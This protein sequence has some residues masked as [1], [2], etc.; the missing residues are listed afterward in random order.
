[1]PSRRPP[2]PFVTFGWFFS[3]LSVHKNIEHES[4][5]PPLLP[6]APGTIIITV[7]IVIKKVGLNWACSFGRCNEASRKISLWILRRMVCCVDE[8]L[9]WAYYGLR[10]FHVLRWRWWRSPWAQWCA[11]TLAARTRDAN[12]P[13]S[14]TKTSLPADRLRAHS[15]MPFE[16]VEDSPALLESRERTRTEWKRE[17]QNKWAVEGFDLVWSTDR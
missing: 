2:D 8:C 13:T 14:A 4:L 10:R 7:T 15:Q 1:V 11:A 16:I 6:P 3:L 12:P 17:R 9:L 5:I